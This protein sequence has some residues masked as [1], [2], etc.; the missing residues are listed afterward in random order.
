MEKNVR[1][2]RSSNWPK[3]GSSSRAC[4]KARHYFRCHGVLTDRN[5]ALLASERTNKQLK[6]SDT[7]T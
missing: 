6:E 3:M 7:D 4:S 5:L 1:E 2:R